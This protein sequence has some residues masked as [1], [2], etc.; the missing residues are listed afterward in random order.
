M[1]NA[2]LDLSGLPEPGTDGE[3]EL[4]RSKLPELQFEFGAIT[5]DEYIGHLAE[6]G[7]V[8]EEFIEGLE[9]R[10]PSAQLRVSPLGE[11]EMLSTHDQMLGGPSGQSYLGAIFPADPAYSWEIM[12]ESVK[13]GERFAKEGIVGRFAIDF[14]TVKVGEDDWQVYAIEVNLRKGGTTAPFLILQYLT[15]GQYDARSGIFHTAKGD[16]KYYVAS[17]HVESDAYRVFTID[18]LFD[19][20][21]E[22][23]LHYN[24]AAQTGV[25]MHLI[26]GVAELGRVGLTAISDSSDEAHALYRRFVEVLDQEAAALAA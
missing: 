21:S 19:I 18:Q 23:H 22:H 6:M 11:V 24:H 8:V 4:I 9:I 14:I 15:D 13:I 10:S 3:V 5:Y 17:D 2:L 20:V 16:P 12:S 1:G 7:A 26:T 25:I